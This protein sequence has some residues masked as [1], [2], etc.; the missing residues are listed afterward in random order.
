MPAARTA[1]PIRRPGP[2]PTSSRATTPLAGTEQLAVGERR[3]RPERLAQT[4]SDTGQEVAERLPVP[5]QQL[6]KDDVAQVDR[7]REE[8]R[9][10]VPPV[11]AHRALAPDAPEQVRLAAGRARDLVPHARARRVGDLQAVGAHSL[12]EVPVV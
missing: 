1:R 4:C 7:Q 2:P 6:A 9:A 12:R 11:V 8:D 5:L 10:A 3:E